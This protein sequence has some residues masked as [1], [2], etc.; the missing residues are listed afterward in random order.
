MFYRN[1]KRTRDD[2][3]QSSLQRADQNKQM[4]YDFLQSVIFMYN[5]QVSG[6]RTLLDVAIQHA[7]KKPQLVQKEDLFGTIAV[8]HRDL[9]LHWA[10]FWIIPIEFSR[11]WCHIEL[12]NARFIFNTSDA[13]PEPEPE[14]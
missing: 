9:P 1:G 2:D 4:A 10:N 6:D 12:E 13:L 3:S 11:V 7:R 8:E 14:P 5:T